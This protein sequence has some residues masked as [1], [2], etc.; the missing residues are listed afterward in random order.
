MAR[1]DRAASCSRN[2]RSAR[3]SYTEVFW[4][5]W[6]APPQPPPRPKRGA[7][8]NELHP[9]CLVG[10][11]PLEGGPC[12]LKVRCAASCATRRAC[13]CRREVMLVAPLPYQGSVPLA[14]LRRRRCCCT[15]AAPRTC[16]GLS[17]LQERSRAVSSCAACECWGDRPVSIRYPPVHS[18]RCRATTPRSPLGRPTRVARA[19]T[20]SGERRQSVRPR[21]YW[22]SASDL[23]RLPSR[24]ERGAH[25]HV[26][27]DTTGRPGRF[28]NVGR[29]FVR[30]PLCL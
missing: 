11:P 23:H 22:S 29:R 14:E 17:A 24:Y 15:G 1:F 18:R 10:A 9:E 25:L 20:A 28:R 26:L 16:A 5:G 2:K 12:G 7:L 4:S 27:A 19:W 30:A 13:W 3:L 6:L 8:L 21:S